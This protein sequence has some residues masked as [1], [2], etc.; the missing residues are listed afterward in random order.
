MGFGLQ[1]VSSE[2]YKDSLPFR[3]P[4]HSGVT[5]RLCPGQLA[6]QWGQLTCIWT[7]TT[8][9]AWGVLWEDGDRHSP[10]EMG[11]QG[12]LLGGGGGE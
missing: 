2:P 6:L 4:R 8:Q 11:G 9:R 7:V 12:R 10:E 3:M 1:V 5:C